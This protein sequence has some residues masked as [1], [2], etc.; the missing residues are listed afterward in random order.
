MHLFRLLLVWICLSSRFTVAAPLQA[1]PPAKLITS[2]PFKQ[3]TGGVIVATGKINDCPDTLNF[4]LDT[5]SGG[6][7]LDSTTCRYLGLT[8]TPSDRFIRGL[9]GLKPVSFAL[10]NT[11]LLPG[12]RIDSLDF[13]INNYDLIGAVYG[14]KIDG[15]IGYS[16]FKDYIV[17]VDYD[18]MKVFVYSPGAYNYGRGGE[19]LKPI[20]GV[21]PVL[22]APL[23][24]KVRVQSR[25]YFDMGAGLCLLLS[26]RFADD[27]S[28]FKGR[29]R[30]RRIIKTEAQGLMGKMEMAI[31]T[32]QE[33]RVGDYVFRNIPTYLFDDVS[34]VTAYPYLGGLIGNDLLR[35]FNVTLNYPQKEIFIKPNSHFKDKF[36]YSYTGLIMYYL[37]GHVVVTDVMKGSPA[38][39]AGFRE[40]DIIFAVNNYFGGDIQQYRELLKDVGSRAHVIIMRKGKLMEKKLRIKSILTR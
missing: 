4:I 36:D 25:Y 21:I 11:L 30:R 29:R 28:L 38:E 34:N 39:E 31:T 37:D 12:L 23:K 22:P 17:K 10:N 32:V 19:L 2:F 8:V 24:N 35:R 5:G 1:A 14:V 15:I 18:S 9:G 27:S 33:I 7:S 3:Y 20:M 13:H 26:N 40:G 6:I 16:F